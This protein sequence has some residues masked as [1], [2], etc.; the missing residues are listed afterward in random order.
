[1]KPRTALPLALASLAVGVALAQQ[2]KA[3]P[4]PKPTPPPNPNAA[5]GDPF[6]V[7]REV[8]KLDARPS[9][10]ALPAST[11]PLE[12]I[13]GEKIALVGGSFS[14]RMNLFGYFESLL[15]TRFAKQQIVFRNFSRPADEVGQ[16]LRPNDYTKLDDPL[17]AFG[18]DTFLCFFGYNESFAGPEGLEPFKAAYEQYLDNTAKNYPR[19][20]AKSAPRFVLISPA[21]AEGSNEN[22]L[23]DAKALNANLKLYAKAVQ[24][25]AAKRKLA[26]VDVFTDTERLFNAE[27]GLQYTINGAHQNEAG[28][29]E[30]AQILDRALFETTSPAKLG[31]PAFEKLRA[32]VNDKSWVH[33]QD[34]RMLNGWY[35]YGGRRTLDTETFPREFVKIRKMAEVRDGVVWAAANNKTIKPDDSKTGDLFTPKG[36]F[37]TK[38]QTEPAELKY[39]TPEESIASMKVPEGFEVQLVASEREFPELAKPDQIN[40][41]NRGRLWVSCMPTYPQWKPGDARPSDR[42]LIFDNF[43]AKGRAQKCTVFYDKLACPTG[44]EFWN[45]GVLVMDEP[46]MLFLKD[47]DGD[48]KADLVIQLTD[49]WATDDTHHTINAWE[50]SHGGL[51][52]M[53]EGVSLTT[54]VE[55]PWGPFRR[56]NASGNYILDPRSLKLRHYVTPGYGNPWCYVYNDWG[57]GF[58]GDGT[59]PQQHWDSP[60]SGAEFSGRKGLA[61]IFDG[62]GMRPNVGN[63]FIITRQFPEEV[64]RLF[65]YAC[66]NNMHGLTT[67]WLNDDGSGYKGARRTKDGKPW[68]LLDAEDKNFRPADPQIGPDGALYFADWHTALLGHMQYS[69]RDPHRDHQ[70]GRVY[71]MVY[72]NRSLLTPVTQAGKSTPE[73]FDQ[74]K[75]YEWRTRYRARRELRDRPAADVLA[76]AKTWAAA[77]DPKSPDYDRLRC[78]VLWAQQSQ[79]AVDLEFARTVLQAKTGD[80]RAAAVRVLSE[81]QVLGFITADQLLS[82]LKPLATDEFGRARLEIIRALSFI[83]TK[84]S[85]ELVL[86][87][88]TAQPRDSWLDYTLDATLSALQGTWKP[89]FAAKSIATDLPDGLALLDAKANSA[90]PNKEA[91]E[92]LK[93]L[94]AGG[95]VASQRPTLIGQIAAAKGNAEQGKAIVRRICVACHKVFNE[96][97]EYG[98]NFAGVGTRLSRHDIIESVLDPN[99]KID[100][101]FATTNLET[102]DGAAMTGF[103]VKEDAETLSFKMPGGLIRDF[104]KSE[105][106]KRETLQQS[107]MPEGLAGTM[108]PQEFIDLVEFLVSLKK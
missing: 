16:Q 52:Q 35:V 80:A 50:W 30:V 85:V 69:Q 99:A 103:I 66:V 14:E 62:Q 32:A 9:R 75:E 18:A 1:M 81:E 58:V 36:G 11:I 10:P 84:D 37:G 87:T 8:M 71:R 33:L 20:D 55:T 3:D 39:L 107:S 42:L 12:F 91:A 78:E 13:K 82:L 45:G 28:D 63:E 86:K 74:L 95:V 15:H 31:S 56:Q 34:Y 24:E 54:A 6:A 64:Q 77:L 57:Q 2:P 97:I 73:L 22:F 17:Y 26:Y 90:Q 51:L 108:S 40:F 61:T 53:L 104:K 65:I 72:K 92:A 43:D 19:D 89:L 101:A 67:F 49:G 7:A 44:F 46:R 5:Q 76:A 79:H 98:P 102:N 100:P 21:A 23:P 96:G 4:K 88:A 48:D 59:T 70:H 68:D 105:I 94:V 27:P 106:K 41:D 47:T 29:R 60:L 38:P 83:A 25:I 93:K